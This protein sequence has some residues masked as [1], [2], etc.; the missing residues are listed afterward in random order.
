MLVLS[1]KKFIG[2]IVLSL[3]LCNVGI[4]ATNDKEKKRLDEIRKNKVLLIKSLTRNDVNDEW[5]KKRSYN[6]LMDL[7]FKRS[8][9]TTTKDYVQYHLYRNFTYDP[10]KDDYASTETF[11]KGY[12]P[13]LN[14][15]I[16]VVCFLTSENTI[17]RLP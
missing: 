6:D 10:Y 3:L 12:V 11:S 13:P 14:E 15:T 9:I 5:L 1:M 2:I 16:N 8:E 17:C 4:S 7:D